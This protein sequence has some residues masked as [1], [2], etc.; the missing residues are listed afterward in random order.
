MEKQ[1]S[2]SQTRVSNAK[3]CPVHEH[4][5]HVSHLQS[6]GCTWTPDLFSARTQNGQLADREK[7]FAEFDKKCIR[8]ELQTTPLRTY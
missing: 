7:I 6:Q 1:W 3:C 5:L 2:H 8:L 4:E